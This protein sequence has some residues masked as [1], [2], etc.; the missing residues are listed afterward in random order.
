MPQHAD[1]HCSTLLRQAGSDAMTRVGG[2][3]SRSSRP[4]AAMPN[5][6]RAVFK[7]D[8]TSWTPFSSISVA[9]P[10]LIAT[11]S[12]APKSAWRRSPSRNDGRSKPWHPAGSTSAS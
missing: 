10:S 9:S 12:A 2:A 8:W 3:S 6:V 5:P 11:R 1:R 4:R 7:L